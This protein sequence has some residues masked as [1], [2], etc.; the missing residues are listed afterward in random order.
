MIEPVVDVD[1]VAIALAE[2]TS[3]TEM[4]AEY[5]SGGAEHV[6]GLNEGPYPHLQ[7]RPSPG[8]EDG[9]LVWSV[10][11][12]VVLLAWAGPDGRP[13]SAALRRLL[14]LAVHHLVRA[15]GRPHVPGRP[16]VTDAYT[17]GSGRLQPDPATG[18]LCWAHT[19]RIVAH[20]DNG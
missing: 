11:G 6:S 9:R 1:P 20:P 2:L 18:Q 19:V 12:E 4:L 8:G 10:T 16:V 7:V 3:A 13:G 5:G 14:Y 17:V 15:A